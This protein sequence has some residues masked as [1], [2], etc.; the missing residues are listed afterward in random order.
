MRAIPIPSLDEPCA[1][2]TLCVGA[3][4][5]TLPLADG[6]LWRYRWRSSV[7]SVLFCGGRSVALHVTYP[8]SPSDARRLAAA[9]L[10]RQARDRTTKVCV[11]AT[12]ALLVGPACPPSARQALDT[13]TAD[14]RPL[15]VRECHE[16]R[17]A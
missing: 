6:L 12:G 4:Y 5:T 14:G 8:D 2:M 1:T 15:V 9:L 17:N 10:R 7:L 3:P 16:L 11:G 13:P